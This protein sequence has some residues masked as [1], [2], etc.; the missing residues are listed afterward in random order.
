MG[1]PHGLPQSIAGGVANLYV[2]AV[3]TIHFF[4]TGLAPGTLSRAE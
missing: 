1:V 3:D 4:F 2:D